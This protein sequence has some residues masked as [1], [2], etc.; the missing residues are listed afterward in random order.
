MFIRLIKILTLA[1]LLFACQQEQP[2][3]R[4]TDTEITNEFNY[5]N[6]SIDLPDTWQ[7]IPN[8]PLVI[9]SYYVPDNENPSDILQASKLQI[10]VLDKNF[11]GMQ[12]NIL[13]WK[14][15]LN[16]PEKVEHSISQL[17]KNTKQIILQDDRR[18]LFILILEIGNENLFIKLYCNANRLKILGAELLKIFHGQIYNNNK[19]VK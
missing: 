8:E 7:R 13:R 4:D 19:T 2:T 17:N 16:D 1:F 10:S 6:V 5:K 9:A 11:G 18:A 14:K 15:Q 3:V 12:S